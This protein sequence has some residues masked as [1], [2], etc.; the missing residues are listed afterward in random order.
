MAL[1][2]SLTAEQSLVGVAFPAA[3]AR[4][5]AVQYDMKTNEVLIFVDIHADQAARVAKKNPI[6][7]NVYKAVNGVD[8]DDL[9][10]NPSVGVKKIC[11]KYLKT[12]PEFQVSTDV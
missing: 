10:A 5:V 9:D 4:I 3:Y 7:G 1:Q 12:L 8:T 11:Y 6:G 2:I